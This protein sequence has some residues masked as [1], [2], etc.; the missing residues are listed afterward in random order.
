MKRTSHQVA[1]MSNCYSLPSPSQLLSE[2]TGSF[3][4]PSIG[5]RRMSGAH[6]SVKR[7]RNGITSLQG[8]NMGGYGGFHGDNPSSDDRTLRKQLTTRAIT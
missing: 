1:T 6:C 3:T 7:S 2:R 8:S 4:E 5:R